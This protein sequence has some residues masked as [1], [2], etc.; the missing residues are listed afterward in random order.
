MPPYPLATPSGSAG[1]GMP[2]PM[3]GG[4]SGATGGAN[5]PY[6]TPYPPATSSYGASGGP[7]GPGMANQS[8]ISEE[9]IKASLISAVE[10][11]IRR[12]VTERRNQYE[13]EMN[14]LS[15]TRDELMEGRSKII[16][17]S[18][19]L[20]NEERDLKSHL[21]MLRTKD[22][23]LGK[24]LETLNRIDRIDVD[25]AVTTTAPLYKQ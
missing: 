25:D 9:H 14:T 22:L 21:E 11:K 13:A 1:G 19:R 6:P 20:E 10:D 5:P 18:C 16:E 17:I 2:Y 4:N 24:Q 12:Q 3:M 7:I 15:R 23:E 8:T